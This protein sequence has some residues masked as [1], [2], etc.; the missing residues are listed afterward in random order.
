MKTLKEAGFTE[1]QAEA[2]AAAFSDVLQANIS[3]L[4]TKHDLETLELRLTIKLGFMLAVAIGAVA[5][6]VKLL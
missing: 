1:S 3:E 5:T 4:A 6:L 2:Q